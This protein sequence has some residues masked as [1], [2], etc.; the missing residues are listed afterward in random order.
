MK[1]PSPSKSPSSHGSKTAKPS[2]SRRNFIVGGAGV[3]A[4][5]AGV[6]WYALRQDGGPFSRGAGSYEIAEQALSP[7]VLGDPE[8]KVHVAEYFSMT[9]G[10]CARFHTN[11]FPEIKQKLIDPGH[12]RFEM[13]PFPLDGAA[14][15]A[16]A[17]ARSVPESRYFAVVDLML[18]RQ[19]QWAGSARPVEA[20]RRLVRVAGVSAEAFDDA[21]QDRELLENIVAVREAANGRWGVNSTPS[22]IIDDRR[23]VS[24]S[25]GYEEFLGQIGG[26]DA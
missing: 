11:T 25:V 6:A 26:I 18:D 16:H 20:L 1:K 22:F 13:R 7:R 23:L 15:A 2:A 4:V 12:I 9:C 17:I 3:V 5:G 21:T 14:L 24:G 8:A 10:H 19:S